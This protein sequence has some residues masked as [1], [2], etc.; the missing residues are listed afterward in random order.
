MK[1]ENYVKQSLH[2]HRIPVMEH[3]LPHII[4]VLSTIYHEQTNLLAFPDLNEEVPVLIVD[5]R[6]IKH[7]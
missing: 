1:A 4:H 6:L 5:P 3:D 2:L 7:D